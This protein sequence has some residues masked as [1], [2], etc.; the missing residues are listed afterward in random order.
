MGPTHRDRLMLRKMTP[1]EYGSWLATVSISYARDKV[2]AGQWLEEDASLRA[3]HELNCLLPEGLSTPGHHILMICDA[4]EAPVGSIWVAAQD[5][6]E[7]SQAYLY[8]LQVWPA[9]RRLGYATA[10]LRELEE[11]V[12]ALGY[13]GIELHVFA[14]N[15]GAYNLYAKTGYRPTGIGMRKT[16][17]HTLDLSQRVT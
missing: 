11:F 17:L 7:A 3:A 16:L 13:S 8:D 10:A 9:F 2:K 14:H 5:S 1:E 15:D 6:L 4:Y 12:N